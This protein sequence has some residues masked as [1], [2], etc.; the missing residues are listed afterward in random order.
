MLDT[1]I[2]I[3][4]YIVGFMVSEIMNGLKIKK[5][6]EKIKNNETKEEISLSSSYYYKRPVILER[7]EK[8]YTV[9]VT[10]EEKQHKCSAALQK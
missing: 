9:M 6:N 7:G 5:L 8:A 10:K 4:I 2:C 1:L 3:V